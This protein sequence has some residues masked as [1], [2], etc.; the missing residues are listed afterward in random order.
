MKF[1]T[2]AQQIEFHKNRMNARIQKRGNRLVV[3]MDKTNN[4]RIRKKANKW[5]DGIQALAFE[6]MLTMTFIS[7][8]T[9]MQE[10]LSKIWANQRKLLTSARK[11]KLRIPGITG[12]LSIDKMYNRTALLEKL[13]EARTPL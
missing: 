2:R 8:D 13:N 7:A 10:T 6:A 12:A 5:L 9:S 3:I 4:V 11:L 1:Q